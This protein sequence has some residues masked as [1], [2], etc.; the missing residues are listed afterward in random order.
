[1]SFPQISDVFPTN[2]LPRCCPGAAPALRCDSRTVVNSSQCFVISSW[3]SHHLKDLSWPFSVFFTQA[4]GLRLRL[5]RTLSGMSMCRTK[6][7]TPLTS[8]TQERE[9]YF[10]HFIFGKLFHCFKASLVPIWPCGT[11]RQWPLLARMYY[12]S[13]DCQKPR[14]LHSSSPTVGNLTHRMEIGYVLKL[15]MFPLLGC[16]LHPI[17]HYISLHLIALI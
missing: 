11:P 5:L 6:R 15:R 3:C 16:S 8:T 2:V 10:L 1:M 17:T 4:K 9:L 13:M 12:T 14:A 7:W